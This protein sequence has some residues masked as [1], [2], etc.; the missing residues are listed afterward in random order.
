[1]DIFK[2]KDVLVKFENNFFLSLIGEKKTENFKISLLIW[3][4]V[5]GCHIKN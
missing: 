2:I 4:V 1:M 5:Q 3:L